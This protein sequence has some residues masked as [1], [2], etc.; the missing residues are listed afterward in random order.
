MIT[1]GQEKYLA[2]LPDGRIVHVAPFDP[3]ARETGTALV[4]EIQTALPEV[5]IHYIGSTVLGIAGE[6]DID[7]SIVS[8]GSFENE[9][10]AL[11]ALYGKPTNYKPE[12]QWA[13]W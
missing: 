5:A 3:L 11:D 13:E 10:S 9:L 1:S 8:A 2:T 12:K 4:A 6:N 7:V